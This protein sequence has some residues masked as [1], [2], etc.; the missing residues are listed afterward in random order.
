MHVKRDAVK[1]EAPRLETY[2]KLTTLTK[3]TDG[4]L[5]DADLTPTKGG[6]VR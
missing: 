4:S 6:G 3:G 1:Y 5:A 2:G